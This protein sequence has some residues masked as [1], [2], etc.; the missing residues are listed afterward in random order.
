MSSG[1]EPTL[2]LYRIPT[3]STGPQ[4]RW[5][6]ARRSPVQACQANPILRAHSDR[7]THSRVANNGRIAHSPRPE[8]SSDHSWK[9]MADGRCATLSSVTPAANPF[10]HLQQAGSGRAVASIVCA[11]SALPTCCNP[12][13]NVAT[14]PSRAPWCS[15]WPP[16]P[17]PSPTWPR[18]APQAP[19]DETF[20]ATSHAAEYPTLP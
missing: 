16:S 5:R 7:L 6:A 17:R 4:V 2:S 10:I 1:A 8:S 15:T 18:P 3:W 12:A 14:H 11:P 20:A 19:A 13:R 9:A